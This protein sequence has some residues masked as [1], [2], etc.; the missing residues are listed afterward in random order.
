MAPN[1]LVIPVV[2]AGLISGFILNRVL[3]RGRSGDG[4]GEISREGMGGLN[5]PEEE[6]ARGFCASLR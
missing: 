1:L 5:P 6:P 3:G 2:L 4:S